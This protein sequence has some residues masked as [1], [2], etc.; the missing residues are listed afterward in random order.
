MAS[1]RWGPLFLQGTYFFWVLLFSACFVYLFSVSSP[2]YYPIFMMLFLKKIFWLLSLLMKTALLFFAAQPPHIFYTNT[3][4]MKRKMRLV[5]ILAATM[6]FI[7]KVAWG[8]QVEKV[9]TQQ[10]QTWVSVNSTLHLSDHWGLIGDIHVRRNNIVNDPSFYFAR[11]GANYWVNEKFTIAAGYAHM[12]QAP[13]KT[14]WETFANERRI[15]QQALLASK[16]D[17]T[18]MLIRIRTEQRWKEIMVNDEASG[19]WG[20]TNRVR[21]LM[22]FGFPLSRKSDKWALVAADEILLNFGKE[23]VFNTFDQNRVFIGLRHKINKVWS[24]DLGYMMVYQQKST[25][26]QYDL[27]HTARWFFYYNPDLRKNKHQPKQLI[28]SREE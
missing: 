13:T 7:V 17:R 9:V 10:V 24:Y 16:I 25:G 21:Y 15:Y 23:V 19:A 22:S 18:G 11:A 14:G 1:N 8:Q 27:N 26:F 4:P 2:L 12:W 28:D 6:F 5:Y 3:S 20:F